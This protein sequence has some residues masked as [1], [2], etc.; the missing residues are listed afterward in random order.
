MSTTRSRY[1]ELG[2]ELIELGEA[3]PQTKQPPMANKVKIDDRS[4]DPL[5]LLL[6]KALEQQRNKMMDSL[7]PT[8][9]KI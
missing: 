7:T 4:R 1:M 2:L 3:F 8:S 5:M 6:Q 9:S